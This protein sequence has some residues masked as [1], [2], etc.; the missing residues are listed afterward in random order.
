MRGKEGGGGRVGGG[1][2][3]GSRLC[4]LTPDTLNTPNGLFLRAM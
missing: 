1:R 2:E 3:R 4:T